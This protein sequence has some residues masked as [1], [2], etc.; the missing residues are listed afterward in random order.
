MNR[1]QALMIYD[2][3]TTI[4]KSPLIIPEEYN[5]AVYGLFDSLPKTR[6]WKRV[7]NKNNFF[8]VVKYL[9]KE[10]EISNK[11]LD[12]LY[13]IYSKKLKEE[14]EQ[15]KIEIDDLFD[16]IRKY[17]INHFNL[18]D[19]VAELTLLNSIDENSY[20]S[21]GFS[22]QRYAIG[23]FL[24]DQTL[25]N[26]F[27]IKNSI[28]HEGYKYFLKAEISKFDFSC[29]TFKY[30]IPIYDMICLYWKN[31][32]NPKVYMP[33]MKD[34]IF[35]KSLNEYVNKEIKIVEVINE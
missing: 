19:I 8:D 22:A 12:E 30:Y 27:N 5:K 13:D 6:K 25:L 23:T 2:K 4:T 26:H 15:R 24:Y 9:R 28:E 1:E 14:Q 21:Q 20:L 33:Y 17:A 29:L 34:S 32:L 16:Q 35:D 18:D 31:G 7:K 10:S 11:S 3:I